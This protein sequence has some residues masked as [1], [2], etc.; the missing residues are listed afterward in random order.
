MRCHVALE[1]LVFRFDDSTKRPRP[2]HPHKYDDS[3]SCSAGSED[4]YRYEQTQSHGN[5]QIGT[6]SRVKTGNRSVESLVEMCFF[7][8]FAR[9]PSEDSIAHRGYC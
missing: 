4:R 9:G 1:V 2:P 5:S 3:M 6:F 8:G 7:L